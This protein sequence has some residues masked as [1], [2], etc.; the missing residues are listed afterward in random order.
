MSWTHCVLSSHTDTARSCVGKPYQHIG[1]ALPYTGI[2]LLKE[3]TLKG[4]IYSGSRHA[5]MFAGGPPVSTQ[6]R[7]PPPAPLSQDQFHCALLQNF[8]V[9]ATDRHKFPDSQAS[10][11]LGGRPLTHSGDFHPARAGGGSEMLL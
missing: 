2:R 4:N 6:L 10:L 3:L 5:L 1:T 11:P 7:P 9:W 8:R